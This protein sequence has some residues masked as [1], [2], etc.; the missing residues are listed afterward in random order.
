MRK[1]RSVRSKKEKGKTPG[2]KR[3]NNSLAMQPPPL[4][5]NDV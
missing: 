5:S 1:P 2:W 4:M 3:G